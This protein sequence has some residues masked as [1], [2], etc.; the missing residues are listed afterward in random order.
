[1]AKTPSP[2]RLTPL[3]FES[4]AAEFRRNAWS[5][6]LKKHGGFDPA[7]NEMKPFKA[8]LHDQ[9]VTRDWEHVCQQSWFYLDSLAAAS[10]AHLFD[11]ESFVSVCFASKVG[12]VRFLDGLRHQIAWV[13]ERHFYAFMRLLDG[14][15]IICAD[16]GRAEKHLRLKYAPDTTPRALANARARGRRK[17]N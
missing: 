8:T 5:K 17:P 12:L 3:G 10:E 11:A 14:E 1:M 15:E 7:T 16:Y 4:E 13:N 9:S 2:S 6:A